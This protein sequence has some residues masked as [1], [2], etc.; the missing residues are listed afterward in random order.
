MSVISITSVRQFGIEIMRSGEAMNRLEKKGR[1]TPFS[2][3]QANLF[4]QVVAKRYEKGSSGRTKV[5]GP[6]STE[7]QNC[8][9]AVRIR[10]W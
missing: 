1:L 10:C 7:R 9:S 5:Y 2:R 3:Q 4:F 8:R 6:A